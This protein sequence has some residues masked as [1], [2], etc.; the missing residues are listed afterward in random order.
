[1]EHLNH[2]QFSFHAPTMHWNR[3][4]YYTHEELR[5]LWKTKMDE[6]EAEQQKKLEAIEKRL[7]ELDYQDEGWYN[8]ADE[9]YHSTHDAGMDV[10]QDELERREEA[11][12]RVKEQS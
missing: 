6:I 1:M 7:K 11:P 9:E 8:K 3:R 10:R 4:N 2:K 12:R 5:L